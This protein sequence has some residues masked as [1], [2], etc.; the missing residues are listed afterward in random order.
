MIYSQHPTHPW[1]SIDYRKIYYRDLKKED[2]EDFFRTEVEITP[3]F[4]NRK[5][6]EYSVTDPN[7]AILI[8]ATWSVGMRFIHMATELLL[9]SSLK[10]LPVFFGGSIIDV[11]LILVGVIGI[12]GIKFLSNYLEKSSKVLACF[13]DLFYVEPPTQNVQIEDGSAMCDSFNKPL[14]GFYIKNVLPYFVF[15]GTVGLVVSVG[16][17]LFNGLGWNNT[18][19]VLKFAIIGVLASSTGKFY[20]VYDK[21]R[22][23]LVLPNHHYQPNFLDK[24]VFK[25]SFFRKLRDFHLI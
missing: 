6:G 3:V 21:A 14:G 24:I 8:K 12:H 9:Y 7:D 22:N 15:G 19:L 18:R 2:T 4:Y 10:D 1:V 23:S 5:T 17:S 11:R 13:K 25:L 20:A 16:A